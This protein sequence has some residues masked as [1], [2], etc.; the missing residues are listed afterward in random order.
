M[1]SSSYDPAIVFDDLYGRNANFD[2]QIFG[3]PVGVGRRQEHSSDPAEALLRRARKRRLRVPS[4]V[5]GTLADTAP[6]LAP[7]SWA[8]SSVVVGGDTPEWRLPLFG[9]IKRRY[10]RELPEPRMVRVDDNESYMEFRRA[11]REPY[12][13]QLERKLATLAAQFDAHVADHH[14]DGRVAALEDAL[15]QHITEA[16]CGGQLIVLPIVECMTGQIECWQDGHEILCTM[17]ILGNDG[18]V[19]MVTTGTQ[20]A[21]HAD[22]V[23][24][25]A[26]A[27][28][29]GIDDIMT[30]GPPMIQ[31]IG[32]SKLVEVLFDIAP[33]TLEAI[34]QHRGTVAIA[35]ETNS[36]LAA[37][38]LLL[39]CCQ[40]GDTRAMREAR[41]LQYED[42]DL[43][44]E[45]AGCLIAAQRAAGGSP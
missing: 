10:D 22:E 41:Q 18:M 28:D 2:Y 16:L 7:F 5:V 31:V 35:P 40:Q 27:E 42:M 13:R 45:A 38:V 26:I 25:C 3:Q 30:F 4:V 37:T 1:A 21:K 9:S 33:K 39:Q 36:T 11:R 24:G 32:A 34:P 15:T 20:V 23:L 6:P 43:V 8:P 12:I 29:L 44:A 19:R 17:R 14:G